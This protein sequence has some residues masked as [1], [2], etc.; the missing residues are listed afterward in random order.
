MPRV[1]PNQKERF[2][3]DE[4]F[5]KLTQDCEV[6][7]SAFRDLQHEERKK[8]F[9][10][11]IKEGYST[12]SFVNT[13]SNLS[14]QFCRNAWSDIREDRLPTPDFVDFSRE[15]GRVNLEAFLIFNGVCVNWVGW[16]DLESLSG[17]A[18][19]VFNFERAQLEEKLR[20]DAMEQAIMKLFEWLDLNIFKISPFSGLFRP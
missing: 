18:K 16:I 15:E 11:S 4:L 2:D 17:K 13:G 12:I 14:L 7:Y 1:I 20:K 8:K 10:E 9:L 6:K 3:K 5:K 19:F